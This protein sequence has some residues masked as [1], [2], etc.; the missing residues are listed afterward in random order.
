MFLCLLPCIA[1][2][3]NS[4]YDYNLPEKMPI[5][6]I[7]TAPEDSDFIWLYSR[8]DKQNGLI[9]YVPAQISLARCDDGDRLYS[10]DAQVKVRGNYTLDYMK[11]SIRIKF[12][13]PQR[14]MQMNDGRKFKSWVL[15]ADW[16]DLSLL[17]NPAAFYLGNAIYGP[18]GYY[19]TDYCPVEV[20]VNNT[21][22]GVYLLVEQQE[23]KAGRTSLSETKKTQTS[24]KT[25]YF[26]ELDTYAEEEAA[27]PNGKGDPTFSITYYKY[28]GAVP[29]FTV[30]S[31]IN[32][33]SQLEFL[34]SYMEKAY[35]I[36]YCA[37]NE[38]RFYTFDP[39]YTTLIPLDNATAQ[40]TISRVI[41][42]PSLVDTYILYEI[43]CNPD[44]GWSSFYIGLDMTAK[45]EKRLIFEAPWDFDSAFGIRRS[46]EIYD[47]PF[48]TNFTNPW[49]ALFRD[50]PWFQDMVRAKWREL[51]ENHVPETMLQLITDYSDRYSLNYTENYRQ[52]PARIIHGN[53]EVVD[54]VNTNKTQQDAALYMYEWLEGRFAWLDE[55]WQ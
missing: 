23:V 49:L 14:M 1:L 34:A 38:N 26:F 16:K 12:D 37:L 31:D 43:C 4:Y 10:V 41:D 39:T 13:K 27:M 29:A 36:V 7:N 53:H 6:R 51:R 32:D 11:K 48:E 44:A 17:N 9:D 47:L 42:I 33:D 22:W 50:V 18:D 30:K 15:L 3:E 5:I 8:E 20:Y 19:C 35:F 54:E 52:W 46:Y 21:Y 25:S 2:G 55:Q 28:D 45:G 24:W 40:E